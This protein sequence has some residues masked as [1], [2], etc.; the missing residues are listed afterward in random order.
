MANLNFDYGLTCNFSSAGVVAGTTSTIEDSLGGTTL[1][2]GHSK[3]KPMAVFIA[4]FGLFVAIAYILENLRPR[5]RLVKP[6]KD[7]A[8]YRERPA[9]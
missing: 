1:V 2:S 6:A 8:D 9:A 3:M 7:D 5:I 4:V